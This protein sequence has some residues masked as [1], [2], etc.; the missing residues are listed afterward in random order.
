MLGYL[1]ALAYVAAG[2]TFWIATA[3]GL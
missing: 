3:A 2:A 1:F